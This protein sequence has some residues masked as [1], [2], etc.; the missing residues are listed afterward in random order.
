M[1]QQSTSRR[2]QSNQE[3]VIAVITGDIV[4]SRA[5]SQSTF[6]QV[7]GNLESLLQVFQA[8][9][10]CEFDI[11]RGDSFQL[12][13][14]AEQ[15]ATMATQIDLTLRSAE[16]AVEVRQCIG[17]GLGGAYQASVKRATGPAY[18]LS[19]HGLDEMKGRGLKVCSDN[20]PFQTHCDL[21]TRFFDS[22][23][24]RLTAVQAAVVV[25]Y[26]NEDNK[27]HEHL[28]SVL[29]KKRSNVTRIL[30]ASQYHLIT[31]YLIYYAEQVKKEFTL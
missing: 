25:A 27:S 17:L 20:V 16:P 26:L 18:L 5:L 6:R 21:M 7:M 30:N 23:L 8:R 1:T 10:L 11:F 28:A 4:D 19:G 24:A 15:A 12:T 22:H 14:A 29:D 13:T 31:D 9:S 2:D 3:K